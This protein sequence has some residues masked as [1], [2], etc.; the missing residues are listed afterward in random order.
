MAFCQRTQ[1]QSLSRQFAWTVRDA[2]TLPRGQIV[3]FRLLHGHIPS[4]NN[5]LLLTLHY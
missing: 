3:V 4:I 5:H 1:E 2:I